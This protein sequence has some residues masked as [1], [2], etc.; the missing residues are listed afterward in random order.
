MSEFVGANSTQY[1]KLPIEVIESQR[2]VLDTLA[3]FGGP[4]ADYIESMVLCKDLETRGSVEAAEAR[5]Y[6]HAVRTMVD[7]GFRYGIEDDGL[8][9]EPACTERELIDA[10]ARHDGFPAEWLENLEGLPANK[11][12]E[13]KGYLNGIRTAIKAG[14]KLNWVDNRKYHF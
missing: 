10:L 14:F 5:G 1:R 8:A 2:I 6:F 3:Q 7:A 12:A 4:S 11:E 9:T 13:S